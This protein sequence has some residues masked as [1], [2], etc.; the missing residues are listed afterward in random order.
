MFP[1]EGKSSL[2]SDCTT[3]AEHNSPQQIAGFPMKIIVI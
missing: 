2:I 3:A 1:L